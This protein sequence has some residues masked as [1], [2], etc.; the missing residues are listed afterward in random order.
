MATFVEM[1]RIQN[2]KTA[3]EQDDPRQTPSC[4]RCH[5][6]VFYPPSSPLAPTSQLFIFLETLCPTR[7]AT[8]VE[9]SKIQN[10]KT[11]KEQDDPR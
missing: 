3:K 4:L 6:Q 1:S 5:V 9:T 2:S 8:F 11:A 7:V 10:S